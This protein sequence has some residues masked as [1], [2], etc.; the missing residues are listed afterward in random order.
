MR[1]P[2]EWLREYVDG[3][4]GG[5]GA[6][7]PPRGDRAARGG[8][9]AGGRRGRAR[10]RDHR[11]PPRLHEPARRRARGGARA[12]APGAPPAGPRQT[13]AGPRASARRRAPRRR[14]GVRCGRPR[15]PRW[16]S[17]I[18]W[19]VPRF[20]ATVIEG[21]RVGPAPEWM[22]RR[23]EAAGVRAV[24]NVVDVTNYVMLETGQPMHAFDYDRIEGRRLVVRRARPGEM[25]ETLDEVVAHARRH[26]AGRGGR[27]RARWRSPASSAGGRPR[28]GRRRPRCCSRRRTGIPRRSP[29]PRAG[30]ACGRRRARGSSGAPIRTSPPRAQAR[31]AVLLAEVAGGRPLPGLVDERPGRIAPRAIRLRP[32]RAVAVLGVEITPGEMARTL[33]ALGC[34]VTPGR[35]PQGGRADVSS[36]PR[37]RGGP[38]RRGHPRARLRSCAAHAAAGRDDAGHGRARRSRRTGACGPCSPAAVSWK[39]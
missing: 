21:V 23:L 7:R 14:A 37:A 31:A 17:R 12:R 32:D 1:V 36:R 2:L 6:G 20:T 38:D 35:T 29:A 13:R 30:S 10:P 8:D 22:R 25:L 5:G 15:R 28:S 34:A 18:P 19:G 26:G 24:N 27:R 16:R 39:R 11:Q 9:R 3:G 4:R 33:R